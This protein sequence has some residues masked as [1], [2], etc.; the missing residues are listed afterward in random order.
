M[1]V[2]KNPYFSK[3]SGIPWEEME[4]GPLELRQ[5]L[6]ARIKACFFNSKIN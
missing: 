4:S 1:F 3:I 5:Y 6:Q 2:F